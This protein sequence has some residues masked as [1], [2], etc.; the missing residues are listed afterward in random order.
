MCPPF[1][2]L[3]LLH[4]GQAHSHP[5]PEA[6]R[7]RVSRCS[8]RWLLS[9]PHRSLSGLR[10][11]A[12]DPAVEARAAARFALARPGFA[13]SGAHSLLLLFTIRP[14]QGRCGRRDW[15]ERTE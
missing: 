3:H 4:G 6:C 2:H 7:T 9:G 13:G 5:T 11:L 1:T 10:A 12:T 8:C 15:L 14:I